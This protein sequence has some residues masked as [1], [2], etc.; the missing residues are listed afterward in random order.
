MRYSNRLGFFIELK[1]I[2]TKQK[3]NVFRREEIFPRGK[4]IWLV[5]R[6]I[7]GVINNTAIYFSVKHMAIG[8]MTMIAASSTIFVFIYGKLLLKEPIQKLNILNI[9]LV[10]CGIL[11]ITKPTF[12]FGSDDTDAYAKDGLAVYAVG[13]LTTL[14]IFMFPVISISL[15]ALKG[16]KIP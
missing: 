16:I 2:N 13:I 4:R 9:V 8:D 14:S 11:L 15:R 1:G 6:S 12:I 3:I 10:L 5:T 7:T